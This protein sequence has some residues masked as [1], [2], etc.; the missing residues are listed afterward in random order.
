MVLA[1]EADR[2]RDTAHTTKRNVTITSAVSRVYNVD[3]YR[4]TACTISRGDNL[5]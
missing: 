1:A 4:A 3:D 2:I 5:H